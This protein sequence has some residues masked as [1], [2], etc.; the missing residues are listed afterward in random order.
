MH[1]EV[2]TV[3]KGPPPLP[4]VKRFQNRITSLLRTWRRGIFACGIL[5]TLTYLLIAIAIYGLIDYFLATGNTTRKISGL[6]LII[7]SSALVLREL[8]RIFRYR[9]SDLARRADALSGSKRNP[10]LS[11][12]ELIREQKGDHTDLQ[13]FLV[14][15]SVDEAGESLNSLTRKEIFPRI[16]FKKQSLR[17]LATAVI[18]GIALYFLWPVASVLLARITQPWKDIPPYSP[19]QFV[20]DPASPEIFYGEDATVNVEISGGDV[21]QPVRFLTRD[22]DAIYETVCFQDGPNRFAQ[23]LE[24]VVKPTE[25]AFAHGRARSCLLYTSPSPRDRG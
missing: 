22:G 19:L 15:R 24:R 9:A 20:V 11:A 2:N 12:L 4:N 3:V 17:F 25:F 10:A 13:S 14:K 18:L 16:A 6:I 7:V 8:I 5:R 21:T 23:K 1:A